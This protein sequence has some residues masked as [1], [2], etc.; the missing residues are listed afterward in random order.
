MSGEQQYLE[1]FVQRSVRIMAE[2][3]PQLAH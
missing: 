2:P 1:D 3:T